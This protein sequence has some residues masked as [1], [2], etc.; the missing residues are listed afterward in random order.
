MSSG[1]AS[2]ARTETS[3][4]LLRRKA[5]N[6]KRFLDFITLRFISLG[7]TM[8]LN[9]IAPINVREKIIAPFAILQ[10]FIIDVVRHK[11]V[12]QAIEANEMIHG[13]LAGVLPGGSA[14]HQKRPIT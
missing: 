6:S 8:G 10:K 12:M 3:L 9:V 4:T 13:S 2:P 1:Y 5:D 11:L 14:F 7:M